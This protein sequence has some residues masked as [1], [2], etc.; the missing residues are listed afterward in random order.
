MPQQSPLETKLPF[1]LATQFTG[2]W[3]KRDEEAKGR[4]LASLL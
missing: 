2:A 1:Q 4:T 3:E